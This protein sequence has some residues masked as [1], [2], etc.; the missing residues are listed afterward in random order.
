[1][2][3]YRAEPRADPTLKIAPPHRFHGNGEKGL[4]ALGGPKSSAM[5]IAR[6][7]SAGL[8]PALRVTAA[9]AAARARGA[10]RR[11]G[12]L[13]GTGAV[14]AGPPSTGAACGR[15]KASRSAASATSAATVLVS[16]PGSG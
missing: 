3:E 10:T 7:I 5:M 15:T 4:K 9:A 12:A 1:G 11:A 13:A 6:R 2:T 14:A 16:S 8:S